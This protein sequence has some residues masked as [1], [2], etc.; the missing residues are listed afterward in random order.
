MAI[1]DQECSTHTHTYTLEIPKA[2]HTSIPT[3]KDTKLKPF[4]RTQCCRSFCVFTNSWWWP[5]GEIHGWNSL[6]GQSNKTIKAIHWVGWSEIKRFADNSPLR[7]GFQTQC[8]LPLRS[9]ITHSISKCFY[10]RMVARSGSHTHTHGN[11][12]NIGEGF[13][14]PVCVQKYVHRCNEY[15]I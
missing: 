11:H 9:T 6:C 10:R 4:S 3:P 15:W 8:K 12:T 5:Q 14:G 2:E 7:H 1:T 13:C